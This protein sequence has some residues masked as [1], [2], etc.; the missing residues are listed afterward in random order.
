[1]NVHSEFISALMDVAGKSVVLEPRIITEIA[2]ILNDF[3][4]AIR[5]NVALKA[6]VEK[7]NKAITENSKLRLEIERLRMAL[8]LALPLLRDD[9][10]EEETGMCYYCG[11]VDNEDTG[12][13]KP[14]CV[15]VAAY[16]EVR[17]ALEVKL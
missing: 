15:Q 1:M 16:L 8:K 13:H 5:N 4:V 14:D 11:G 10:M 2:S 12:D 9:V 3:E 7:G 6:E 17:A